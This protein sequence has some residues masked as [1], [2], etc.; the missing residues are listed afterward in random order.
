MTLG[1]FKK[2]LFDGKVTFDRTRVSNVILESRDYISELNL[3][4][5]NFVVKNPFD[6][7]GE[8]LNRELVCVKAYNNQVLIVI[9]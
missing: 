5:G 2:Y 1:E 6:L 9:R 7:K 3:K 4:P 8:V